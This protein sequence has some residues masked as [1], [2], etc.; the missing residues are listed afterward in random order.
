M[1]CQ[2]I[3]CEP[4]TKSILNQEKYV[5]KWEMFGFPHVGFL[6]ILFTLAVVYWEINWKWLLLT[7][8]VEQWDKWN[9]F[10]TWT[11]DVNDF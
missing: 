1:N 10:L 4:I 5:F 6:I 8:H 3:H 2:L 7:I 9:W 11:D